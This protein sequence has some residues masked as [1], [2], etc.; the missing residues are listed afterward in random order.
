MQRHISKLTYGQAQL[1]ATFCGHASC[2]YLAAPIHITK[3]NIS[4]I[5]SA[6][7]LAPA[8]NH[9]CY[10]EVGRAPVTWTLIQHY[11][12]VPW[13]ST[14]INTNSSCTKAH[15][16]TSC[17]QPVLVL[18]RHMLMQYRHHGKML[19][20]ISAHR[21]SLFQKNRVYPINQHVLPV[22]VALLSGGA[23]TAVLH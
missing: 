8:D 23:S 20:V 22:A 11:Q 6:H 16:C 17:P 1:T 13:V 14:S 2:Q 21:P 5:W 9:L 10:K 12:P 15:L 3:C 19:A 4:N 18:K 7:S